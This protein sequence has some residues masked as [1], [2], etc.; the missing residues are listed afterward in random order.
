MTSRA[1]SEP[2]ERGLLPRPS[3][4]HLLGVDQ[5]GR[6]EFSRILYGARFSLLIGVVSVAVGVSAG[7]GVGALSGYIGGGID[8][9]IMRFMDIMLAIP[10]C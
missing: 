2:A 4:D 8:N 7:L 6:D 5:L 9:V 10:G 3:R 1:G